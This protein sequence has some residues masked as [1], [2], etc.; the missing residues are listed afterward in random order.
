MAYPFS[1]YLIYQNKSVVP[2][3]GIQADFCHIS[4]FLMKLI[5]AP[6]HLLIQA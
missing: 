6:F 2:N 4:L 3:Y 5:F 1:I